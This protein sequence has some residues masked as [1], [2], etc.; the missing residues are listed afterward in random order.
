MEQKQRKLL[1]SR[2]Y[3][4]AIKGNIDKLDYTIN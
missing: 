1:T 3:W 2:H 4:A